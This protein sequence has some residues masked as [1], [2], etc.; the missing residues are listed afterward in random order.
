VA[1]PKEP[2]PDR[3][4]STTAADTLRLADAQQ[5]SN[6]IHTEAPMHPGSPDTELATPPISTRARR[7]PASTARSNSPLAS[8]P[9][10]TTGSGR[11]TFDRTL[12]EDGL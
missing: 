10:F 9:R 4:S 1:N 11:H 12:A 3:V 7:G 6:A 5:S 8:R 2:I